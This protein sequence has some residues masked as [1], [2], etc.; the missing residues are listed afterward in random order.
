MASNEERDHL[1]DNVVSVQLLPT[2]GVFGLQH[3]GQNVRMAGRLAS[4]YVLHPL[5]DELFRYSVAGRNVLVV[6]RAR[7]PHE[8]RHQLGSTVSIP[9]LRQCPDHCSHKGVHL[10]CVERVEPRGKATEANRVEGEARH[11]VSDVNVLA[12]SQ[13]LPLEKHLLGNIDHGRIHATNSQRAKGWNEN[14]VCL[15]PIGVIRVGGEQAIAH[16]GLQCPQDGRKILLKSAFITQLIHNL[17]RTDK[18]HVLAKLSKL[19]HRAVLIH[20]SNEGL[21]WSSSKNQV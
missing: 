9:T 10:L 3:S 7:R 14:A 2:Y 6:L 13:S 8:V 5:F 17:L 11:H 19:E 1:V 4:R 15:D 18:D 20:Q 16:N 12:W 21:D